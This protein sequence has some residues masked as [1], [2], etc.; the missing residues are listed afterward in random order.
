VPLPTYNFEIRMQDLTR[1]VQV[2][3]DIGEFNG[4]V[5]ANRLVLGP[6]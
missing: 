6:G 2:L 4:N 3:K 5:D 1:W